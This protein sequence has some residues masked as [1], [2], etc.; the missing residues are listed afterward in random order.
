MYVYGLYCQRYVVIVVRITGD[1]ERR[2]VFFE[3]SELDGT[4]NDKIT[5]EGLTA[6]TG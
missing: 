4:H 2:F 5:G 3:T 6:M 1:A